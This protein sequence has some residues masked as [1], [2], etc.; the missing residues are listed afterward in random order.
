MFGV[1][2]AALVVSMA[3]TGCKDSSGTAPSSKID[4]KLVGVW[5]ASGT[6]FEFKSDGTVI[7][8]TL[9]HEVPLGTATTSNG[10]IYFSGQEYASY[11]ISSDNK[12]TLTIVGGMVSIE[13]TKK[14][15][16]GSGNGNS[17]G[18]PALEGRWN[19]ANGN[20]WIFN[21]DGSAR[22]FINTTLRDYP[23]YRTAN[24]ILYVMWQGDERGYSYSINGNRLTV[25]IDASEQTYTKQ[26]GTTP[27]VERDP[28][29]LGRW[30]SDGDPSN[31]FNTSLN[32]R[33]NG[34]VTEISRSGT[35]YTH[36]WRTTDDRL[37][38]TM[39]GVETVYARYAISGNTLTLT[40]SVSGGTLV[41]IYFKEGTTGGTDPSGNDSRLVLNANQA[42]TDAHKYPAGMRD[43]FIFNSNG[44]CYAID[45]EEGFWDIWGQGTWSTSG[46]TLT[47]IIYG[48]PM[49][50][51]YS[52]SGNTLTFY[53]EEYSV[54][55]NVMVSLNKKAQSANKRDI[56]SKLSKLS[57]I[58]KN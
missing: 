36:T 41:L 53:G 55:N 50:A 25:R 43:G 37:W 29:L 44:T 10:K 32:F 31:I 12:L 3:L 7:Q 13:F 19:A 23:S 5:E 46:N 48:I 16:S 21:A 34:N 15:S 52:I 9:G 49:S 28:A 56:E 30:D 33:E 40:R 22:S 11:T 38:L 18:D 57:E 14:G 58:W 39:N 54:T 4:N 2:F 8:T 1:L 51:T 20:Y 26:G 27:T 45:D 42:W 6:S 35:S 17:G 24:D 47:V